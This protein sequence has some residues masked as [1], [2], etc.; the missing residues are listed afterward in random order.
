MGR[1]VE[2]VEAVGRRRERV[3]L[4]VRVA[5]ED[6]G[7]QRLEILSEGLADRGRPVRVQEAKVEVGILPQPLL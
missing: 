2:V 5:V 3:L 1:I 4:E 6:R 7:G